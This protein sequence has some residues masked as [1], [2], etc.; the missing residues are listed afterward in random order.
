MAT[1]PNSQLSKNVMIMDFNQID[2][3]RAST[4]AYM[5]AAKGKKVASSEE[6]KDGQIIT[7]SN[8]SQL[9]LIFVSQTKQT[10]DYCFEYGATDK[11][12]K[13]PYIKPQLRMD[14]QYKIGPAF[15]SLIYKK[16]RENIK[17]IKEFQTNNKIHAIY[18]IPLSKSVKAGAKVLSHADIIMGQI[19]VD[20]A[21]DGRDLLMIK[22]GRNNGHDTYTEEHG[23][24]EW[25]F[26]DKAL[27]HGGKTSDEGGW[28]FGE[29]FNFIW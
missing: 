8:G 26:E 17:V 16:Y 22:S 23:T 5:A 2:R 7:G 6:L 9:Q 24:E 10:G 14:T 29:W 28:L 20:I 21:D 11:A 18:R 15:I 25:G 1:D 12:K 19:V 13:Y 27:V 3:R 4:L